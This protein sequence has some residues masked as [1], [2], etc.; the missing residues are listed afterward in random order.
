M[1]SSERFFGQAATELHYLSRLL[2]KAQEDPE[3]NERGV[4]EHYA[5]PPPILP[6][7]L[8]Q[9]LVQPVQHEHVTYIVA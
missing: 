7:S 8:G 1:P 9:K 6:H 5:Q 4:D 2:G 3:E